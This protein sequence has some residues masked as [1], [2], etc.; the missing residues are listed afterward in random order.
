MAS[1]SD[2]LRL[3]T[4]YNPADSDEQGYR[5]EMLDLA[6]V[7]HDPFD[8]TQ[9]EPGHFTASGFVVHPDGDQVLLIHHAKIGAWLQPGGH[10]DPG[11]RSALGAAV[12]EIAEETGAV[13][14]TPVTEAAVDVDIHIFPERSDQPEHRH[15]DVRFALVAADSNLTANHEVLEVRWATLAEAAVLN[16]DRSVVRPIRKLLSGLSSDG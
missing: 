9:Y 11:D 5:R 2:L 8:R 7:A 10:I 3:L 13:D 12:R 4:A 14:L 6:A 1:R 16:P 15:Y